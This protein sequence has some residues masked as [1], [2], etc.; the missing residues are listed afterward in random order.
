LKMNEQIRGV[1]PYW[2]D[3]LREDEVLI[4]LAIARK[5]YNEKLRSE[6]V[7]FREV[8]FKENW[9]R[10][11][12]KLL[13]LVRHYPGR[14]RPEDYSIYITYNPRNL[15]KALRLFKLRLV[16]WEFNAVNSKNLSQCLM[17][18]KKLD[19]EFIS[20]LQKPEARS[21][22]WHFLIDVDD[23]SK[24]DEVYDRIDKLDL[25]ICGESETKNGRHILVRPFN[26]KLWEPMEGV[27]VKRDGLFHIFHYD[28]V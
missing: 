12:K 9:E 17:H 15:I 18:L 22:K 14:A 16:D 26:L 7:V 20:C 28:Q 8:V 4:M 25:I 3:K 23:R 2:F 19:R 27:E 21:R 11:F 24:L 13:T 6:E 5:K 1:W 10:K